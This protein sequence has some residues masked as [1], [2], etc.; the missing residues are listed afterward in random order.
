MKY[1]PHLFG[2]IGIILF[3]LFFIEVLDYNEENKI[4]ILVVFSLSMICFNLFM[5]GTEHNQEYYLK[6]QKENSK[7]IIKTNIV[8]MFM[9][10]IFLILLFLHYLE[11]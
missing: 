8:L 11:S 5:I 3:T 2:I 10:V 9:E 7:F 4:R 1:L 6:Q